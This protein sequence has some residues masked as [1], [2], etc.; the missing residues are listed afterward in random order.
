MAQKS[1]PVIENAILVPLNYPT[2]VDGYLI[3]AKD[4]LEGAEQL[5]TISDIPPRSCLLLAAQSLENTLKAFLQHKGVENYTPGIKS[6]WKI[7]H[8][9]GLRNSPN[10]PSWVK[11]INLLHHETHFLRYQRGNEQI[12]GVISNG[13]AYP[14]TETVIIELKMLFE[15]VTTICKP[16]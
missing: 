6:L 16:N 13:T 3:S 2:Q 1:N 14:K 7:A 12:K 11:V 8:K 9:F 4:F 5:S 15:D 10:L